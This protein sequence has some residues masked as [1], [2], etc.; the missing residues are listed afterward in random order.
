MTAGR[1][2]TGDDALAFP[3]S[4]TAEPSFSMT[5][6][7]SWPMV[8]PRATGYS[9]F[10]MWM[11]VPQIVVVVMRTS[12]SSGPMSGMALPPLLAPCCVTR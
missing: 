1:D 10:R 7:G 8:R 12:A 4:S 5:P 2:G 6:T 9:P 3:E 11:S